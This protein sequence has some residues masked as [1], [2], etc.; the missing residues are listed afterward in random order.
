MSFKIKM[1]RKLLKKPY[2]LANFRVGRTVYTKIVNFS[3]DT[4]VWGDGFY[5]FD[6]NA[7]TIEKN[8][9]KTKEK[10][11][12]NTNSWAHWEEGF[13]VIEFDANSCT[14]RYWSENKNNLPTSQA[15]Q[16]TNKKWIAATEA[17]I[18]RKQKNK[19]LMAIMIGIVM[20][21]VTM[22]V[23]IMVYNNVNSL[24][25][26]INLRMD[27]LTAIIMNGRTG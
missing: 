3:K 24:G 4:I 23:A 17:E 27:N 6:K 16:A 9:G 21:V 11:V 7:I 26:T 5:I 2:G 20:S 14:P 22:G 12:Y 15:I 8:A 13:P 10:N 18:M 25:A 1:M 19:L